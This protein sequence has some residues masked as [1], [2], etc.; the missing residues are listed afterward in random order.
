MCHSFIL[1]RL[2]LLVFS[3][4]HRF[5]HLHLLSLLFLVPGFIL[6]PGSPTDI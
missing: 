3:P 4:L 6:Q 5:E 1:L 2:L